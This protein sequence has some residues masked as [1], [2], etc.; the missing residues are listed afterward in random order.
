MKRR[1]WTNIKR[2]EEEKELNKYK[3]RRRR[4]GNELV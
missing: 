3:K 2:G 1:K 4:E